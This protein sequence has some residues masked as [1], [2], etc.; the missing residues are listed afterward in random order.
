MLRMIVCLTVPT[1][2]VGSKAPTFSCVS[3]TNEQVELEG[4]LAQDKE[5]TC[6][7]LG[8]LIG[9]PRRAS[10]FCCGSIQEPVLAAEPR[11]GSSS[12]HFWYAPVV[13]CMLMD[14]LT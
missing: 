9:Y 3:H 10:L 6:P 11:R 5:P 2:Q 4:L 7:S 13:L 8:I 1:A 14:G 12:S